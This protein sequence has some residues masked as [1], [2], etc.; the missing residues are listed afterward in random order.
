METS[1]LVS[2]IRVLANT[3]GISETVIAKELGLS[4][5]EVHRLISQYA[6]QVLHALRQQRLQAAIQDYEDGL[7]IH[8]ILSRNSISQGTLYKLLHE[9]NIPLR[10]EA[11][12]LATDSQVIQLYRAHKTLYEIK[13]R[14]H[15]STQYI[16]DTLRKHNIPLRRGNLTLSP[17]TTIEEILPT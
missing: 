3:P 16:Y 7:P 13:A 8:A 6:P 2:I 11:M 12:S 10:S 15:R 9:R 14:T 4:A 17:D 5:R 1:N